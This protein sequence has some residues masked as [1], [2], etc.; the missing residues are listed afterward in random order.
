M[1]ESDT[2]PISYTLEPKGIELI[3][4]ARAEMRTGTVLIGIYGP[5]GELIERVG[6]GKMTLKNWR[7]PV[8]IRGTYTLRVTPQHAAGRWEVHVRERP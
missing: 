1:V 3:I 4:R 8:T 7:V 6:G 2:E 5:N